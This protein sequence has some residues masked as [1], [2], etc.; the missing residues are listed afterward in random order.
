MTFG[1]FPTKISSKSLATCILGGMVPFISPTME[2]AETISRP[3]ILLIVADDLSPENFGFHGGQ[4]IPTPNI[5]RMAGEGIAFDNVWTTPMCMPSR[6]QI[7]TG[8]NATRTGIWHN[9]LNVRPD[10][11]NPNEFSRHHPTISM[12]LREVGYRTALAGK[13]HAIGTG[14]AGTTNLNPSNAGYDQWSIFDSSGLLSDA[15]HW[16]T[17]DT[18]PGFRGPVASR[19]WQPSVFEN[20]EPRLTE[21]EDFGD[22]LFAD[23][24]LDFMEETAATGQPSLSIFMMNLPHTVAGG[25]PNLPSTPLTGVPGDNRSGTFQECV[26]YIDVIVG[27][28]VD[29]LEEIGILENTIV[30]FT[31][32]NADV[33]F[34]KTVIV[35]QGARVPMVIIGPE[36]F[37]QPSYR[38][39][40]LVSLADLLPTFADWAGAPVPTLDEI[41]GVNLAPYLRGESEAPR[42]WLYSY[43]GTG[44]TIR[45]AEWVLDAHDEIGGH[46]GR[47][48]RYPEPYGNILDT[49]REAIPADTTDPEAIAARARLIEI[50]S[51]VHRFEVDNPNV[52]RA[53]ERYSRAAWPHR[54]NPV[55]PRSNP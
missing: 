46:E 31:T 18:P 55:S 29:R 53:L 9:Q 24:L 3:N 5:D 47:L 40:A 22:D 12:V 48:Y 16:E 42:S 13:A 11:R 39:G 19:H 7:L 15:Q 4:R 38:T 8:S 50:L 25:H 35:E 33:G 23:F 30:I 1:K 49:G 28:M 36:Q 34:G 20:G 2:A 14:M 37:I 26:E 6:A 10:G 32:D 27:R 21:P 45:D 54:L 51:E 43:L 52:K 17:E 44:A 41:D